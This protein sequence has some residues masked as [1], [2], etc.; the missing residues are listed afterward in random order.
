[1]PHV[2]EYVGHIDVAPALNPAEVA[3]LRAARSTTTADTGHADSLG[4][5]L[6]GRRARTD[7][8]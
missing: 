2:T 8:G 7:D 5:G 6:P 4:S 1:M 3:Y